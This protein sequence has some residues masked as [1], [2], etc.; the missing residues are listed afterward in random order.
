MKNILTLIVFLEVCT[1]F[2]QNQKLK[3]SEIDECS[4]LVVSSKSDHL[5]WAHNDSGDIAR[6]FLI[7]DKGNT[8][9]TYNYNKEVVDCEDIALQYQPNGKSKLF[10]GDIG[11]N[12]AKRDYISIYVFNEPSVN[13]VSKFPFKIK[14]LTELKFKYPDGPR[15]AECLLVDSRDQKIY[16]VS[17]RENKVG[18]YSAP[19]DSKPGKIITLKKE[20]TLFFD[21]PIGSK[22]VVAGDIS[23]DGKEVVIK[24][25]VNIYYWDRHENETLSQCLK[26]PY[27]GLPYKPEVQG[28]AIGL[29]RSGR[30]Y[31]TIPEGKF[32]EITF[33]KI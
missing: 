5:M 4:G 2:A 30:Y 11:D 26:Q 6:F 15:D 33:K 25:Y 9:A 31:Y 20:T 29:T 1:C 18:V 8:L 21:A 32:A 24:T 23:R 3:S 13:L 22:W 7:D 12:Y 19:L 14:A 27:I 28:E 10:I 17:K 16:I